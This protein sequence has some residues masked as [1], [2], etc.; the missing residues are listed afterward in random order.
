M[1]SAQSVAL[2]P[3]DKDVYVASDEGLSIFERNAG[4]GELTQ[5][6]GAQGCIVSKAGGSCTRGRSLRYPWSLVV[7]RDGLSAYVVSAESN[8]LAIFRRDPV[9]GVLQQLPGR[10]GCVSDSGSSGRCAEGRALTNPHAV[11]VSADG[12]SVYTTASDDNAVA[13]FDR[14]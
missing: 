12:R 3:D 5:K 1:G 11:T 13:I 7:S 8:A 4:N 2:S 10:A 6:R 14:R 9:T